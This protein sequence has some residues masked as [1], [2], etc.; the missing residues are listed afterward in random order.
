MQAKS[1]QSKQ[2]QTVKTQPQSPNNMKSQHPNMKTRNLILAFTVWLLITGAFVGQAQAGTLLGITSPV[3]GITPIDLTTEGVSDWTYWGTYALA[4]FDRKAAG[5]GEITNYTLVGTPTAARLGNSPTPFSWTDGAPNSPVAWTAGALYFPGL[6]NGYEVTVAAD[7]TPRLFNIYVGAWNANVQ[8]EATL[9]DGSASGYTNNT[10]SYTPGGPI[11]RYSIIY[12]ANSAGQAL[13]VRAWVTSDAGGGNVWLQAASL[14]PVPALNVTQPTVSLT[15]NVAAGSL[16][17]LSAVVQG[18]FP[19]YYQWQVDSGG[20][21]VPVSNSNTNPLAVDTTSLNGNYDYRVVVTN[22]SGGAVTSAPVTLTVNTPTGVL[23]ATSA[24]PLAGAEINLTTDGPLDWAHWGAALWSDF[25]HKAAVTQQIANY[26]QVGDPLATVLN[27]ANNSQTFT[28][29]DGTPL[30]ST[31]LTPTGIYVVG[32]GNGFEVTVGAEQTNRVLNLHVGIYSPS[33][34]STMRLEA[35][36]SDGSAPFFIDES[37]TGSANRRY[38]F[39]FAAGSAGQT[40]QVKYWLTGSAD[41][42]VTLQAATLQGG[43]LSVSQP[44]IWPASTLAAGSMLKLSAQ[45]VGPFPYS[46]QW[47]E[48]SGSG[49]A[50]ISN[51]DTN[52]LYYV[53]PLSPGNYAYRVVVTNTSSQSATSAPVALTVTAAA[54]KVVVTSRDVSVLETNNFTTEGVIDWCQWGRSTTLPPDQNNNHKAGVTPQIINTNF[55]AVGVS[56]ITR[57]AVGKV[58]IRWT[59]GTPVGTTTP[60]RTML[61]AYNIGSGIQMQAGTATTNR[62]LKVYVSARASRTRLEVSLSDGSAPFYFNESLVGP[63]T[64]DGADRVYYIVYAAPAATSLI[65]KHIV[66]EA[67]GTG[68]AYARLRGASLMPQPVITES[69][70][71]GNIQLTWPVGSLLEAT[72]VSGPWVANPNTSPYTLAPADPQKFFRVQVP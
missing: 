55:T 66:T 62:V 47:Q 36:L 11:R 31:N 60:T 16:V 45:G 32:L 2:D 72:N 29:S 10:I 25:D 71:G 51:S 59:D 8:F 18:E 12:A 68:F 44:A 52:R 23:V 1:F 58:Y 20:G 13:K 54:S 50:A 65:V 41:G 43:S 67:T 21:Y 7:T 40:L 24:T 53:A 30:A 70:I 61:S 19:Y 5:S 34:A 46:Y 42:N 49:F 28:W 35:T 64:S 33:I 37:L 27:Y 69:V 14:A 38:S 9:S 57:A 6:S 63:D 48:D 15:N 39:I 56:N 22:T 17:T 26:T 3:T 4:D